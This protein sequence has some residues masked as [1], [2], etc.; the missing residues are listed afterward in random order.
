[1]GADVNILKKGF[2][3]SGSDHTLEADV[4][5]KCLKTGLGKL[6]AFRACSFRK[7]DLVGT[8]SGLVNRRAFVRTSKLVR[9]R[10]FVTRTWTNGDLRSPYLGE[11]YALSQRTIVPASSAKPSIFSVRARTCSLSSF[12]PDR[13]IFLFLPRHL[14]RQGS[15][16]DERN[17]I[18][19]NPLSCGVLLDY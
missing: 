14:L 16:E 3:Q 17:I 1:M 18:S 6:D 11:K 2:G 5:T 12:H 19:V 10:D 15:P 4:L 8:T 13:W 9:N 7:P